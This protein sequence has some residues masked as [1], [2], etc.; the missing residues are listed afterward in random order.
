MSLFVLIAS[1]YFLRKTIAIIMSLRLRRVQIKEG[2]MKIFDFVAFDSSG[3][4]KLG[5]IKARSMSEAKKKIQQMGFYLAS[6]ETQDV[7]VS[8]SQSFFSFIE[9]LKELFLLRR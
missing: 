8:N 7:S 2:K 5:A 1:M 6:I 4:K 3:K 9:I